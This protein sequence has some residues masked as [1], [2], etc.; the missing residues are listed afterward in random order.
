[1]VK[2]FDFRHWDFVAY[3]FRR[4]NFGG[5]F[6]WTFTLIYVSIRELV[7]GG[8]CFLETQLKRLYDIK[9]Q[10]RFLSD[11]ASVLRLFETI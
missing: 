1:M 7:N 6:Q 2:A 4:G 5:S 11:I 3:A 8:E 9:P 10:K